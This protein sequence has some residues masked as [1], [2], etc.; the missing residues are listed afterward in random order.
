M[1]LH[2]ISC[3]RKEVTLIETT[4]GTLLVR[5]CRDHHTTQVESNGGSRNFY[6]SDGCLVS[7]MPNINFAAAKN[8]FLSSF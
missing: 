8:V 2:M 1:F 7:Y 4:N 5:Y 6:R 3:V